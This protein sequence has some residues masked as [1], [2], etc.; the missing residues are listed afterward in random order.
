MSG[1]STDEFTIRLARAGDLNGLLDMYLGFE[2]KLEFQGLPPSTEDRIK[3]WLL[4][5]LKERNVNFV[6]ETGDGHLAGHAVLCRDARDRAELAIFL[7][8]AYR[9]KGLGEQLMQ[10]VVSFG[11]Q[12]L[13]LKKIWLTVETLNSAAVALYR[14]LGF[15]ETVKLGHFA[16]ELIMER[17]VSCP[18]CEE[19]KCPVFEKRV[20]LRVTLSYQAPAK[21]SGPG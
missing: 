16:S 7:H 14:K 8:Q 1:S 12:C 11:C 6:I 4:D 17:E 15:V 13:H 19:D 5:L 21:Q 20:P 3:R 18:V 9:G 10:A 2:P